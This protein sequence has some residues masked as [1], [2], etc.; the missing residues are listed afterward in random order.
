MET[1]SSSFTSRRPAAVSLPAFSLPSPS[2]VIPR[3][4]DGISPSLS[5][6]HTGSSQGSQP[7]S[8]MAPYNIGHMHGSWQ[9]PGHSSYNLSSTA[10]QSPLN[11]G[12]YTGQR[13]SLYSQS[14]SMGYGAQR[15]SQSPTAGPGGEALP[16]PPDHHVHQPFPSPL[17]GHAGGGASSYPQSAANGMMPSHSSSQSPAQ[18]HNLPH[19]DS[20][21]NGR[22]PSGYPLSSTNPAQS[23]FPSY[24]S[25]QSPNQASPA[26]A[27]PGMRNLGAMAPPAP[28]RPPFGSYSPLPGVNGAVMSNVHHPGGSMSMVGSMGVPGYHGHPM[29]YGQAPPTAQERPFKCDVCIQAFSRN[30]D[31]KRHKRIHLSVKPFPCPNCTKSFSRKDALKRHK[32]VKGC[33]K[34]DADKSSPDGAES[35]DIDDE[36][37]EGVRN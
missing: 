11:I 32:L 37:K 6:V 3:A 29:I 1:A 13:P 17:G 34:K 14:P 26:S 27:G 23:A 35:A 16:P 33:D 22:G 5:S 25:L 28:Y 19:L 15:D 4:V 10:Q 31:L 12:S 30:H 24:S 21:S 20:Y 9:T 18:S 36:L 8:H 2:S 7:Q